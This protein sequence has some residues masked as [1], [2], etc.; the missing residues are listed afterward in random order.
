MKSSATTMAVGKRKLF[1]FTRST[2]LEIISALFILL[3]V[4]TALSKFFEF[5]DFK[6]VLGR[7]PLIS[8]YNTLAAWT[9]PIVELIV[10]LMLFIPRTRILGLI[11][12]LVLMT[13]FT[14]YIGYMLA[15]TPSLP[16]SC[17]GV[18]KSMTWGQH[19]T[20]NIFFTLLAATGIWISKKKQTLP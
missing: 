13:L 20:F 17:G 4:Y 12:S 3:F 7:S 2:V 5:A 8:N 1:H 11:S 19:L 9:L 15:F 10:S 16:C 6:N 14:L 18:L